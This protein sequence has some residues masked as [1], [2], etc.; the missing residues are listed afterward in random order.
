MSSNKVVLVLDPGEAE[1]LA[2]SNPITPE[3]PCVCGATQPAHYCPVQAKAKAKLR[4]ALQQEGQVEELVEY[5]V[6]ARRPLSVK[7]DDL[8]VVCPSAATL[9]YA[10]GQLQHARSQ[11]KLPRARI[12]TKTETTFT[13]DWIDLDGE[14]GDR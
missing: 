7:E 10:D 4:A 8:I 5:R 14:E 2:V 1:S 3:T 12:Q 11:R 6:V 9:T 13:T